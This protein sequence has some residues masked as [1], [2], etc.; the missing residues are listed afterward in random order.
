[1][2]VKVGKKC[3]KVRFLHVLQAVLAVPETQHF[4]GRAQSFA[5]FELLEGIDVTI[6]REDYKAL[7]KSQFGGIV[8]MGSRNKF[9]AQLVHYCLLHQLKTRKTHETW[10]SLQ[11]HHVRFSLQEFALMTGLNCSPPPGMSW[12]GTTRSALTSF[13]RRGVKMK[14]VESAWAH[15][16]L[17]ESGSLMKKYKLA[18]LV[19]VEGI[20]FG[21]EKKTQIRG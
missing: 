6:D 7:C 4:S 5:N 2:V 19:I 10:Y 11:G 13:L 20:L 17:T 1:M 3:V 12:R 16:K 21:L 15:E 14:D 9:A 8:K 18:L